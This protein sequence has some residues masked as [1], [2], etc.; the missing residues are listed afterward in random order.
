MAE[1]KCSL[2]NMLN[3][4]LG[5]A[6]QEQNQVLPPLVYEAM[7]NATTSFLISALVKQYPSN[8]VVIDMLR[9]F[10]KVD[11]IPIS[12]GF[13]T[14]PD[15]YR[16][17]LGTPNI[18]AKIDG[19]GECGEPITTDAGM[20]AAA[21]K[22][23]CLQR[24]VIILPQSEFA[25]RTT[26]SYKFPTY[27]DPIGYMSGNNK[28]KLCPYDLTKVELMYVIQE[29]KAIFGYIAQPDDSY[30]FNPLTSTEV[31]WSSAAFNPM[32]S[33]LSYL[34]AAYTR[35][36]DLADWAKVLTEANILGT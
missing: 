26:S 1:S 11:M 15:D 28:I 10:V 31:N 14:L 6:N 33:M 32:Y 22:S 13:L 4:V 3:A 19:S 27:N 29:P 36:R 7:Y 25:Y 8:P 30:V 12:N 20:Q 5:F 23:K 2:N 16:D 9:P 17:I 35:D 34:L 21:N 18:S 24:P